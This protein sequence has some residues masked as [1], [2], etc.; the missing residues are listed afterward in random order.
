MDQKTAIL[1]AK[2]PE[3]KYLVNKTR[4][5][6][7]WALK[8]VDNPYVACSFGK[9]SSAMLHLVLQESP[10]IKVK[11]LGK[12]ETTLIDDYESIIKWWRGQGA[13]IEHITY[14]GW[15]EGGKKTGIAQN[16]EADG[17]DSFFV[18]IRKEESVARR[19]TI[20]KNGK[21][22]KMKDGKT[23]IS[24]MAEWSTNDIA[25]YMLSNDLPVLR[26]Y[27]REGFEARTTSNIPS[28]FPHE[29]LAR[30]K[31]ADISAY[32]QLLKMLPDAKYFT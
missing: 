25:A 11:F 13:D 7:R 15:L 23:R 19:I 1:Y 4:Y 17:Y 6:I 28:K 18:G 16:M 14:L 21:F 9:D 30:L 10:N 20:K 22:Y 3:Y 12:R 29:S 32:N 5:F 8:H 31:D 26:A 24:P 27:L 2:L